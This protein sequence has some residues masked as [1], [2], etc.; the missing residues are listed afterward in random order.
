MRPG[1]PSLQRRDLKLM[2]I[3]SASNKSGRLLFGARI[4]KAIHEVIHVMK[5]AYEVDWDD[6]TGM[7]NREKNTLG[8]VEQVV[9]YFILFAVGE[10]VRGHDFQ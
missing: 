6:T 3:G 9:S 8:R 1:N 7:K 2:D 4:G 10:V 5:N